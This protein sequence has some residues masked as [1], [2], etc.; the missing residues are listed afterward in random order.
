MSSPLL[1]AVLS[2]VSSASGSSCFSQTFCGIC[3]DT[4]K[5][6]SVLLLFALPRRANHRTCSTSSANI[7]TI[8]FTE[9]QTDGLRMGPCYMVSHSSGSTC[10]LLYLKLLFLFFHIFSI[11]QAWNRIYVD[12]TLSL[13]SLIFFFEQ[14]SSFKM[15]SCLLR[16]C[17]LFLIS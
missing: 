7:L 3:Q 12:I 2:F 1:D 6:A 9:T 13:S 15:N 14:Q 8:H 5:S 17:V 16:R 10:F 11:L 4:M